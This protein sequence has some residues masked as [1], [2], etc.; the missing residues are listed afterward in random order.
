[1]SLKAFLDSLFKIKIIRYGLVGGFVAFA[2]LVFFFV[3]AELLAFNYLWIN[4]IGFIA[5]TLINYYLCIVFIFKSGSRFQTHNEVIAIFFI[6][7]TALL[8][9]QGII[10][11]LVEKAFLALMPAKI[12]TVLAVF[13]WNY[14]GRKHLVFAENDK[15]QESVS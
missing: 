9:N 11:V 3:C 15:Q 5:G 14:L 7:G 6:S 8:L 12:L 10:Y 2:D 4:A 13:T 1:M